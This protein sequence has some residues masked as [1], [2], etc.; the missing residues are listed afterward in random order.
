[1]LKLK[2]IGEKLALTA[3]NQLKILKNSVLRSALGF[4]DRR[5][6]KAVKRESKLFQ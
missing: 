4:K 3:L 5:L 6:V 2:I 1:M